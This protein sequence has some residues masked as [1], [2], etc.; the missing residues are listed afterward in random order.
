MSEY[1]PITAN[2]VCVYPKSV[3]EIIQHAISFTLFGTLVIFGTP[4]YDLR[5]AR[6]G[7]QMGYCLWAPECDWRRHWSRPSIIILYNGLNQYL[8][9]VGFFRLASFP[10]MS[11]SV[12]IS[13]AL[14]LMVY[15]R[16]IL[17]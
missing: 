2:R 12:F 14:Y 10:N 13:F 16:P 15:D 6:E 17:L 5:Q 9:V 11:D 8:V 3:N 4:H 1:S 7:P